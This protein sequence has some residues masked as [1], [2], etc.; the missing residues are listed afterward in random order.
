MRAIEK[1]LRMRLKNAEARVQELQTEL[2]EVRQDRQKF[3][4]HFMQRFKWWIELI[5]SQ[6]TP[7]LPWLIE[8]DA[9][10]LRKFQYFIW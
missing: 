8:D 3:R 4:D 7:S 1:R 10:E 2:N 9:K 5:G 6:Q